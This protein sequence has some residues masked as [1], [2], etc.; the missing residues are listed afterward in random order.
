MQKIRKDLFPDVIYEGKTYTNGDVSPLVQ[1]VKQEGYKGKIVV[2]GE[3]SIGKSA[4]GRKSVCI[5]QFAGSNG[6]P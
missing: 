2:A 4:P 5:L 6:C 3:G 1:I